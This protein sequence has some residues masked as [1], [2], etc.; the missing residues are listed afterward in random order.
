MPP[1]HTLYADIFYSKNLI[2]VLSNETLEKNLKAYPAFNEQYTK[3]S[4]SKQPS[5][6]S[7]FDLEDYIVY[8]ITS[9][10]KKSDAMFF[11]HYNFD[12][13]DCNL[14]VLNE[15]KKEITQGLEFLK[16]DFKGEPYTS[17]KFINN[18]PMNTV[19]N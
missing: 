15:Y 16:Q 8:F 12:F 4:A 18:N 13:K 2:S 14:M 6:L 19:V 11:I 10:D 7:I 9:I 3:M 5:L 1:K 17:I